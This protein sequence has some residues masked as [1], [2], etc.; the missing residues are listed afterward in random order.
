MAFW[1]NAYNAFVLQTVINNFP[2]PGKAGEYPAGE[3]PAVPARSRRSAMRRGQVGHARR[4]REEDSPGVQGAASLP[5]LRRGAVGSS[6]LLSEAYTAAKVGAQLA[7]IRPSSSTNSRCCGSI[8]PRIRLGDVHHQLAGR[9]S[10]R[11]TTKGDSVPTANGPD[12]ARDRRVRPAH[13]L[14]LEGTDPKNTFKV[15]FHPLDWRLNDLT[16]GRPGGD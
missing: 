1:V 16:G 3:H 11:R 12:R 9:S 13:L 5:A 8:A 6:R 14:P 10:S 4:D 15:A 2:D 7:A